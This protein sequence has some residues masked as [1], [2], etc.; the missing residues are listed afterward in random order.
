MPN[1]K[2]YPTEVLKKLPTG[3]LSCLF[4][5]AYTQHRLHP[6]E[7]NQLEEICSAISKKSAEMRFDFLDYMISRFK[8][9]VKLENYEY[10]AELRDMINFYEKRVI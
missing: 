3:R 10:A 9:A 5:N 1:I 8:E 7:Q 4:L 6:H 2:Q